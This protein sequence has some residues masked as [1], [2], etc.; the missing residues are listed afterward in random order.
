MEELLAYFE[1]VGQDTS[2]KKQGGSPGEGETYHE[3][4]KDPF[5]EGDRQ[6]GL[7]EEH[8]TCIF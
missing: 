3:D 4:K 6:P 5:G 2:L 7:C 8:A 1:T